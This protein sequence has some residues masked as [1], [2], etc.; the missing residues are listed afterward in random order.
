MIQMAKFDK[1]TLRGWY[2]LREEIDFS[3]PYQRQGRIWSREDKA[4]LI[5]SIL[6]DYD[7]PKFYVTNYNVLDDFL[8]FR[9]LNTKKLPYA[10]I[11]GKQRFEAI[12]DF[13]ED[14]FS[15]D[16]NFIYYKDSAIKLSGLTY[17]QIKGKYPL[18][19]Q[20]FEDYIIDVTSVI[21][22]DPSQINELFIRLNRGKP[23]TEAEIRTAM[24]GVVPKLIEKISD[25]KFF[26]DSIRFSINRGQHKDV[27]AK[28]LLV[29]F[30]GTLVDVGGKKITR[31]VNEGYLSQTTGFKIS[32]DRVIEILN[33]MA[34]IFLSQ[35]ELLSNPNRVLVFYWFTRNHNETPD[36]RQFF[37]SFESERALNSKKS[38]TKPKL[39]N[40]ELLVFNLLEAEEPDSCESLTKRYQ[41]LEDKYNLFQIFKS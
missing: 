4:F 2:A 6:N 14:K 16:S 15:L 36:I 5:D 18:V 10:I 19:A 17:S 3:P 35:D 11:D 25:H 1:K 40:Q 20:N 26:R 30:R 33:I 8:A 7:I 41:I 29:E 27:A 31:F 39:A 22:D 21:T 9:K 24:K 23:L 13:F 34:H 12:F 37:K 38:K 28:L 32:A